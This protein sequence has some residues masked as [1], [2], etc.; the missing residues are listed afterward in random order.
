VPRLKPAIVLLVASLA[1]LAL[2]VP[3][4]ADI[5]A[6]VVDDSPVVTA[7]GGAAFFALMTDVGLKELRL[8]VQWDPANP[9]VVANE[10]YLA[11]ML[12]VATLRGVRVV[13]SVQQLK[14]RSVTGTP[15]GAQQ[16]AAFVAQLATTFPTVK[17][18]IVGN[19]PNL[20]RFWQPQFTGR[21]SASPAA[22]EALLARS[23]D[24][25]KAVSPTNNVIGLGL[26]PRGNDAPNAPGNVSHSPVKFLRGLGEAYRASGRRKPL[27]DMFAFHP[28]PK[29]DR[30]PLAKGYPW[31]NAGVPNL[32]RIK[33]AFYDA[34]HGTSQQTFEQG[35]KMKLDEVG[36]QVGVVTGS[37]GAYFGEESIQ[38]TDEGTQA[39]IYAALLKQVA[40]D[41]AVSS[42]LFFG[43]RDEANLD[44]W[45]SGLMRA[46][47]STRASYGAVKATLAQTG[48]RC[49]GRLR[50]WRH[51]MELEGVSAN[52]PNLGR[53]P[54]RANS[55]SLV[56][57]AEEDALFDAGIHRFNGRR[58]T[59]VL[60]ETGRLEGHMGRLV[61]LPSRR[62][63]PGRYV[64]SI[65]F[66]AA[67]NP[68][69]TMRLTGRPFTVYRAR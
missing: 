67:M 40:C 15:N 34:F 35:L 2:A 19:E 7:D 44:R 18:F 28:Y 10:A 8:T 45:Q 13:F 58:G 9:T 1:S 22:Y 65:R 23:Y 52:F 36:W 43:F 17:D 26:S 60:V 69:R 62:L 49:T 20:S 47:G 14:A 48:G 3:A 25:L 46:D 39:A 55:W 27:M 16:F 12:P 30:D 4:Q 33:Q 57:R 53:L 68:A 6:G 32:G 31:P 24:A 54:S 21:R 66:R 38:P 63:S 37:Q 61:R 56:A 41:P 51:S 64:F 59:R 42:V 50:S 29:K 11:S 5:D